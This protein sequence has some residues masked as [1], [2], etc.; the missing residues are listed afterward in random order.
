MVTHGWVTAR[1]S[2]GSRSR[3][4]FGQKSRWILPPVKK[5]ERKEKEEER[6]ELGV[7]EE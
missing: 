5:K 1:P 3:L 6:K 4:F 2:R 7:R